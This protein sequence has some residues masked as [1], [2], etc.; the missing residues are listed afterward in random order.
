MGSTDQALGLLIEEVTARIQAG[1]PI[2][3]EAYVRKHPEHAERLRQLLP[4]LHLLA[5]LGRSA[6]LGAPSAL[7]LAAPGDDLSGTLGDF[8][9]VREVGRGGMGVVYEAEQISLGRRV[10]LKV[11]P[12]AAALD[13]RQ[14]QRFKNEAQ[15]AAHLQHQNIVPVYGVGCERGVHFYA[16]QF[17]DGHTL[18]ELIEQLRRG[19][20]RG[21]CPEATGPYTPAAGGDGP[22]AAT[23]PVAGGLSTGCSSRSPAFFQ[24]MARLVAQAALALEHAHSLGVVHRDIKPANLLLDARTNLWVTDFGLAQV[25]SDTR[26]TMTGDLVGTLRYM[27]PEQ[28][29]AQR[30]GIDHR[31]DIYSLGATLYELLTLEPAF[32]DRDRQELLRLIAFEEPRRP[33]RWNP[34]IPVELETIVLKALTKNPVERYGT[35]QELADDLERWLRDEPIRARRPTVVQRG[36][37]WARR[38][39]AVVWTSA[40][41]GVVLL[42]VLGSAAWWLAQKQVRAEAVLASSL[43][44]ARRLQA[45][46]KWP[47]AL[48]VARR[49]EAHVES[50]EGTK[51]QARQVREL[52]ADLEM[53][54]QVENIRLTRNALLVRIDGRIRTAHSP[55]VTDRAYAAAFRDYGIDVD[56]L[57]PAAAVDR[58]RARKIR[59]VLAVSLD[60]WAL[61]RKN[62]RAVKEARWKDLF[63]LARQVDP[64]EHRNDLR[65]ALAQN[66]TAAIRRVVANPEV[67]QQPVATLTL[68]GRCLGELTTPEEAVPFLRRAHLLHPDDFWINM[69]LGYW[70]RSGKVQRWE[71]AARCYTAALVRRPTDAFVWNCLGVA[72]RKT[73]DEEKSEAALRKAVALKPDFH[74]AHYNLG[75]MLSARGKKDEALAA[76]WETIRLDP[77]FPEGHYD[78]GLVL[79]EK[80]A[81]EEASRAYKEAIRLRPNFAMA[82]CNLGQALMNMGR[83]TEALVSYRRGHALGLKDPKWDFPS[84]DWIRHCERLIALDKRLPE[85]LRGEAKPANVAERLQFAR[86]CMFKGQYT[87]TARFHEE[88]FATNPELA[89]DQFW[90]CYNAACAAAMAGCGQGDAVGLNETDRARWRKQAL[91]WLRAEL[92][93][94]LRYLANPQAK[95]HLARNTLRQWQQ[96]FYLARVRDDAA[97]DTFPD[98][99]QEAWRRLWADVAKALRKLPAA[100]PAPAK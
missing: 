19:E 30:V 96:D 79:R 82:H 72:L 39:R 61:V 51:E 75:L 53:I 89:N 41:F 58:I 37:R 29:L 92:T 69:E 55:E 18:A 11:L 68:V 50:G 22:V 21:E 13:A 54:F 36:R 81:L 59:V 99:E 78:L 23:P 56:G 91:A 27:S 65:A 64:D 46:S 67:L 43:D 42:V 3:V 28:A 7:S 31:T 94:W 44:E 1:Q 10:A 100:R 97:L 52:L 83:F 49:A 98:T 93:R 60:D 45:Q 8:R 14:L 95:T 32:A 86:V 84:R 15:A 87:A 2:D 9:I 66:D 34:A 38:H 25:H 71:E 48:A 16:M 80:G 73:G 35:A 47:E 57:D 74:F 33:R 77:S 5:D 70:L 20:D 17:I 62:V 4:A 76:F 26:L 63:E 12:F 6:A 90:N 88:A 85:I 24:A 40:V